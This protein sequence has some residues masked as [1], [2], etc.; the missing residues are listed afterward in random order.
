[1]LVSKSN[2]KK[3]RTQNAIEFL[4]TYSWAIIIMVLVLS[5]LVVLGAFNL[6][7]SAG[8]TCVINLAFQC[9]N[10]SLSENGLLSFTLLQ[11]KY[12]YLNIT[13]VGC[14]ENSSNEH[15]T[16]FTTS[17]QVY[18]PDGQEH[19]F[20]IQC[21][22]QTNGKFSGTIGAQLAASIYVTY[23]DDVSGFPYSSTGKVFTKISSLS[24]TTS[25]TTSTTTIFPSGSTY[26]Y[27]ANFG[28]VN[29]SYLSQTGN[30]A[31]IDTATNTVVGYIT[32]NALNAT[33]GLAYSA[34]TGYIYAIS[35]GGS[36]DGGIFDGNVIVIINPTTNTIIG[37]INQNQFGGTGELGT[38][39]AVAPSG[40]YAYVPNYGSPTGVQILS[41]STDELAG[42]V[43][44]IPA[45][46][47]LGICGASVAFS[48]SGTYAYITQ[49]D[50]SNVLI[51]D[52]A[53]STVVNTI[54]T[55]VS[56]PVSVAFSPSGTYAY[57]ANAGSNN[58]V[59][60]DTA[61]NT[62]VNSVSGSFSF[63]DTQYGI[64][65]G[66]GDAITFSPSGTYAYV[67]NT[68]IGTISIISTASNSVVSTITSGLNE[69]SGVVF[70]PS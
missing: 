21:Y 12:S 20:T 36:T 40:T 57:V 17:N 25:S 24:P 5:T 8:T 64:G 37:G 26:A 19:I 55:G 35:Y 31:I 13:G 62:V 10:V 60:I 70:L 16:S 69:P 48:P 1:M 52:T 34:Y 58:V 68:G 6:Q 54:N 9:F 33:N 43:L 42:N 3:L 41:L 49:N 2:G 11:N 39:I 61:T 56:Y 66:A 59:I 38:G 23:V 29:P 14:S 30:I 50:T 46:C 7:L 65:L 53:T 45:G 27:V 51:V 4:T 63:Y 32:S 67:T 22:N 47:T 28:G 15:I 44:D 18:L